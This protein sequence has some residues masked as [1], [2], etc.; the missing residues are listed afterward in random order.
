MWS[1]K[2]D[3]P[4]WFPPDY[5]MHLLRGTGALR[6]IIYKFIIIKIF[7]KILFKSDGKLPNYFFDD[8]VL[9]VFQN[10]YIFKEMKH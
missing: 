9:I 7:F 10:N 1:V 6:F 2:L 8:I 5:S 3:D 4:M